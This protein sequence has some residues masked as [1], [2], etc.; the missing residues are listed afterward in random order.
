M[1]SSEQT[2]SA[3][4]HV[5]S[6]VYMEPPKGK[7]IL[8]KIKKFFDDLWFRLTFKGLICKPNGA[9]KLKGINKKNVIYGSYDK[10]QRCFIIKMN[11]D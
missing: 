8:K 3:S 6:N 4:Y 10:E 9:Y 1:G 7:N 5:T 2:T 11:G